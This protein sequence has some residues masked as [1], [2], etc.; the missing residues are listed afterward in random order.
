[1]QHYVIKFVSHDITEILLKVALNT[2]TQPPLD[3]IS[4]GINLE[5]SI[6]EEIILTKLIFLTSKL[7]FP[8]Y[9]QNYHFCMYATS[10]TA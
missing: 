5:Y 6:I 4:C 2:R 3:G 10:T 9:I 8:H 1:M 7:D